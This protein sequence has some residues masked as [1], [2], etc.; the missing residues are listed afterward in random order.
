MA[1]TIDGSGNSSA[2]P[3]IHGQADGKLF[4]YGIT[5]R[6]SIEEKQ[7]L[8]N[9]LMELVRRRANHMI[10]EFGIQ[11][12]ST[13]S[14][15]AG[16]GANWQGPDGM[17]ADDLLADICELIVIINDQEIVD[18]AINHLC[19]Q[20][21]DMIRTGGWCPTGR[22]SRIFQVYMILRDY[23]DGIGPSHSL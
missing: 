3:D 22:C 23:L 13:I 21:A 16:Q 2:F 18:T 1:H 15:D 5:S 11:A 8:I 17:F 14:R 10:M 4:R 6:F 20:F 12:L 9:G 7:K 19:E